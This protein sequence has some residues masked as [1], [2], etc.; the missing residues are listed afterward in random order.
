MSEVTRCA[1]CL[2]EISLGN[3]RICRTK[4]EPDYYGIEPAYESNL[5]IWCYKHP[6]IELPCFSKETI[7]KMYQIKSTGEKSHMIKWKDDSND[8]TKITEN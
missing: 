2:Q 1:I 3:K 6:V 7:E 4:I 5:S 8:Y